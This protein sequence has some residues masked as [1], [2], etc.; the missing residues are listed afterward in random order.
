MKRTSRDIRVVNRF[1]VL[2][3]ILAGPAVSRQEIAAQ[4]QL[5]F[6]TVSSS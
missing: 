2:R 3:H 6:A 5:S 4:T 1:N